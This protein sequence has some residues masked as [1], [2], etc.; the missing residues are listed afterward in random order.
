M[1]TK[2]ESKYTKIDLKESF[3]Y[4]RKFSDTFLHMLST[5]KELKEKSI[6]QQIVVLIQIVCIFERLIS[7]HIGKKE[8]RRIK[9]NV[10]KH[11]KIDNEGSR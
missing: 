5:S 10:N 9:K 2:K 8:Y 4:S 7:N 1:F 3:D 11:L 6:E